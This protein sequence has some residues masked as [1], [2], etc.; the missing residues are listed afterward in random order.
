MAAAPQV[1]PTQEAGELF[2]PALGTTIKL[3]EW[4]EDDFY[5][6]VTQASGAVT[7]GTTL[8]LFR[9]LANKNLQHSNLKTPRRIPAGSELI[10]NRIGVLI[11]QA[12]SNTV[13][14]INDVLKCAYDASFTFKLNDRL[15]T[16][17][18]L[19]KYS[20]G[21][22]VAGGTTENNVS[23]A[24]TGVP[25]Q[26]AA[27]QLLVSQPIKDDDDLQGEITFKNDIWVTGTSVMP[28][29]T[30]RVVFTVP[31]HGFVKKPQGK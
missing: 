17:G 15:V 28:T 14:V 23:T 11:A 21:M 4:R 19:V 6:S 2:I 25:S 27:P 3:V 8:D 18:P 24:T 1:R 10:M 13:V 7:A 26:A 20:T 31:L 30:G 29:L 9:D 16:E 22:G 5:D 12:F